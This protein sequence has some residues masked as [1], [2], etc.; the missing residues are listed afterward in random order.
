MMYLGGPS[1]LPQLMWSRVASEIAKLAMQ[2]V[3]TAMPLDI[4]S[5]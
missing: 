1:V 4:N 3:N 5:K 2:W